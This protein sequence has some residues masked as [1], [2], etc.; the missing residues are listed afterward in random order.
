MRGDRKSR[1]RLFRGWKLPGT[2]GQICARTH[3]THRAHWTHRG[4]LMRQ[5]QILLS[6]GFSDR[7]I[8]P[9]AD[10]V[11]VFHGADIC[12][13]SW[14]SVPLSLPDPRTSHQRA[15]GWHFSRKTL[16][17]SRISIRLFSG[18]SEGNCCTS[19]AGPAVF[20]ESGSERFPPVSKAPTRKS[21]RAGGR[22]I[23]RGGCLP[24]RAG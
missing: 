4:Q 10:R 14:E 22:T 17:V 15:R 13:R 2:G 1:Q 20:Q 16:P 12:N 11:R 3:W 24:C 8:A 21:C 5:V 6:N 19:R 18:R 9:L 23:C 7:E